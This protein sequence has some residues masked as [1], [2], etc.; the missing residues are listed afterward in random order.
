[1]TDRVRAHLEE[2]AELVRVAEDG[3]VPA[4]QDG[5]ERP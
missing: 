5:A 4:A 3:G 2:I 1:M